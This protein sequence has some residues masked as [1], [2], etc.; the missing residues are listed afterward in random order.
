MTAASPVSTASHCRAGDPAGHARRR[1]RGQG[2]HWRYLLPGRISALAVQARQEVLPG[3]LRRRD[4]RQQS[5][6]AR[7][8]DP[9]A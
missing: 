2:R 3:Q 6:P 9:A 7:S 1:G 8:R 5:P 4:P